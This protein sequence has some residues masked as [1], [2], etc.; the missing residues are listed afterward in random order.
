MA[1]ER[2]VLLDTTEAIVSRLGVGIVRDLEAVFVL[3]TL[4][5]TCDNWRAVI[6]T[7]ANLRHGMLFAVVGVHG[8]GNGAVDFALHG[9]VEGHKLVVGVRLEKVSFGLYE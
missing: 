8:R 4:S 2:S 7:L 3:G 1:V 6:H 5:V 9:R